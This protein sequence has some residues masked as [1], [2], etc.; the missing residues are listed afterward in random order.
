VATD[1]A[2]LPEGRL[3][4]SVKEAR[5]LLGIG[6]TLIYDLLAQGK[7]H[8]VKAGRRILIPKTSLDKFLAGE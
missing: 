4:Y 3:A 8:S 5:M 1:E 6:E 7:L 2:A